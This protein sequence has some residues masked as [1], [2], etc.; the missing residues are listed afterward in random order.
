MTKFVT[1]LLPPHMAFLF[2]AQLNVVPCLAHALLKLMPYLHHS[3]SEQHIPELYSIL[4]PH[5]PALWI[6]PTLILS[7][8]VFYIACF[9]IVACFFLFWC[10][11][12][13]TLSLELFV[14]IPIYNITEQ[15][16]TIVL[17]VL[18]YGHRYNYWL[19]GAA[20]KSLYLLHVICFLLYFENVPFVRKTTISWMRCLIYLFVL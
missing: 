19:E 5:S 11:L 20:A 16:Q 17:I 3:L 1:K 14:R 2:W 8:V 13:V 18:Y 12:Q 15:Y 4:K 6:I 9:F 7:A 10:Q